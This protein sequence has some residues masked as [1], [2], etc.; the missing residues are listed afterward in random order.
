MKKIKR[1]ACMVL[2]G[3]MLWTL[4]GCAP[5]AGETR[6]I[7]EDTSFRERVALTGDSVAVVR[8]DGTVRGTYVLH[9]TADEAELWE[10]FAQAAE[11]TEEI[12]EW[13][14]ICGITFGR[15]FV[16]G[17]RK[18]STAIGAGLNENLLNGME[19]WRDVKQIDSCYKTVVA[20]FEDGTVG[21][22]GECIWPSFE[23]WEDITEISC[24]LMNVAAGLKKDGTVVYGCDCKE[25]DE[26]E[27]HEKIREEIKDWKDI[28]QVACGTHS[29]L[30]LKKDGTVVAAGDNRYGECTV[31]GW[32]DVVQVVG[33]DYRNF[34]IRSDGT[35]LVTDW[36][37]AIEEL[38]SDFIDISA[39][40]DWQDI[41]VLKDD[42]NLVMGVTADGELR[43]AGNMEDK[44]VQAARKIWLE[45]EWG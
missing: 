33:G 20:L 28:T 14:N 2:C 45:A 19:S 30:G 23:E 41:V 26:Q 37:K 42:S 12:N 36:M 4:A 38:D 27:A 15:W 11:R 24:G 9:G 1:M 43:F 35:V 18:D 32:T 31:D 13:E 6:P 34:G 21:N 5:A 10:I 3:M 39:I 8:K 16:A 7:P 22:T 17:L 44:R 29:V 25:D 40:E